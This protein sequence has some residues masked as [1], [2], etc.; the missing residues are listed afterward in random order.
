MDIV[1]LT[2]GI[3]DLLVSARYCCDA[4]VEWALTLSLDSGTTWRAW[5]LCGT[6]RVMDLER[7]SAWVGVGQSTVVATSPV[8]SG[9]APAGERALARITVTSHSSADSC[10]FQDSS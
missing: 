9:L 6:P 1:Q 4:V 10:C 7:P 8:L 2:C 5:T 3:N